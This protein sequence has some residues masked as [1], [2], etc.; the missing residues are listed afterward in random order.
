MP[1][2]EFQ[3][4]VMDAIEEASLLRSTMAKPEHLL[5]GLLRNEGSLAEKILRQ[6][7][8]DLAS[9]HTKLGAT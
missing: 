3:K 9:L 4:V 1:N 6:V 2:E 7:G 5:L 8:L